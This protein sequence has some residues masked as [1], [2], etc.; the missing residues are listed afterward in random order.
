MGR[1]RTLLRAA[2]QGLLAGLAGV[3]V[4]TAG[5]KLEQAVS[6][7]PN[8]YVPARALL[9]LLGRNPAPDA[10]PPGWNHAMH[11]GTGAVLGA[12]RGIWS[13]T[14]IRGPVANTTFSVVRLATDQT[15]ENATGI[16]APPTSWPRPETV[17][18]VWHKAVYAWAT[19]LLADAWIAPVL[20]SRQGTTSH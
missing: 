3:A 2:G 12:L 9:S 11:W 8:S 5:E 14:G 7:R 15:L 19:G 4:M 18:D 13:V 16:G 10:Q 6:R 1:K 17:V 20:E